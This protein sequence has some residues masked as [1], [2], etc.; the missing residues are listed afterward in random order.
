MPD[1]G[2]VDLTGEAVDEKAKELRPDLVIKGIVAKT[3]VEGID[4][5]IEGAEAIEVALP[6]GPDS[7]GRDFLFGE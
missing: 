4:D 1:L 7:D 6:E 2:K 5:R 3:A